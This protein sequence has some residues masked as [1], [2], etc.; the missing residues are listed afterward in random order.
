[1]SKISGKLETEEAV[2]SHQRRITHSTPQKTLK[3][4]LPCHRKTGGGLEKKS[5]PIWAAGSKPQKRPAL[6]MGEN[7]NGKSQMPPIRS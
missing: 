2:F 7:P 3:H 5:L 4:P 6:V 1:M